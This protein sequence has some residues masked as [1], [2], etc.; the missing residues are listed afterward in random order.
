MDVPLRPLTAPLHEPNFLRGAST[1]ERNSSSAEFDSV[2]KPT[3]LRSRTLRRRFESICNIWQ[4]FQQWKIARSYVGWK[5][6]LKVGAASAAVVFLI[7]TLFLVVTLSTADRGEEGHA[8][9]LAG[10]CP[11]VRRLNTALHAYIN[12][13]STLLL[14]AS[15][16]SMQCLS[17]PTRQDID[18]AH[19]KKI[20]LDIGVPS[21]RNLRHIGLRYTFLWACLAITSFIIHLL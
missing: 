7:N 3:L 16:F 15:S 20:W 18:K 10:S 19:A 13:A 4:R 17:A 6:S 2:S 5:F 12:I 14:T 11:K 1:S 21:L 9:I 8:V